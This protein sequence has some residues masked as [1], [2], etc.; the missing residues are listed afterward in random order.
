MLYCCFSRVQQ[1]AAWFLQ[2]CWLETPTLA[3]IESLNLVINWVQLW[4]VRDHSPGAMK[5]RV[6]CS[7]CW[8][9]LRTPCTG[10]CMSCVAEGQIILLSTMCLITTNIC[11]DSKISYQYC[12]LTFHFKLDNEQLLLTQ[13]STSR[14]TW[15]KLSVWYTRFVGLVWCIRLILLRMKAVQLWSSD[16]MNVF[17]V[18]AGKT[19]TIWYD[20]VD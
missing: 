7:R 5:L 19:T 15:W 20:T 17:C 3:G 18:S 10:S 13:R 9:E 11:W 14:Q 2:F 16:N 8:T 12:P 1:V 6:L 4:P